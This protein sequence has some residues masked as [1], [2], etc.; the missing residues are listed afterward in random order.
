MT[1]PMAA[2][3]AFHLLEAIPASRTNA[4]SYIQPSNY[5]PFSLDRSLFTSELSKVPLEFTPEAEAAATVFAIPNP[6]GMLQRFEI[7][8]TQVMHPD[9]AKKF[10]EIKT[11][12]GQGLDD[13]SASVR[14]DITPAGFH[15]QVLSP[16]G[17]YYIDPYYHL[18]DSVY[19]SY[20]RSDL[21]LDPETE[22]LRSELS[23]TLETDFA[24]DESG[25]GAAGN[26]LERTGPTLRTYRLA[27]AATGEYTA[28]HG[29]TVAAGQAAIVTAINRVTG[30]WEVEM[31]IRLQLVPN[32]DLL[33]YT[34]AA[35]DPYTNNN[36]VTMLSENQTNV[37]NVIGSANYDIGHVF[38]TGGGGVASLGVVG[39]NSSK[40]RGVTGLP[41]PIGDPFY[42]DYVIHE[43]GHQFG[44]NHT[45][46]G[47]S[48]S[49]AGNRAASAAYEPGS[50]STIMAYAGICG[51][52]NL[53]NNSDPYFHSKSF[54]EI[55]NYVD[56]I[57]PSVGTRTSTGN[58]APVADAGPNFVIPAN[59]PFKLNGSGSDPNGDAITYQWEQR[60]L[61]PQQDVLA[62]DNG[63]SPLF[64]SWTPTSTP[65]RYFPRLSN[66]VNNSTVKGEK[67]ALTNRNLNFRLVVRDNRSG[68]GGVNT[69]D[70]LINVVNTGAA[71]QVTSPNS[72][73][74]WPVGSTQTV[75]WNVSGTDSGTI[76]TPGVN[77]LLSIDGGLTYP[78]VIATNVPNDGSQDIVVPNLPGSTAR[79]MVEGAGNI[80]FDISNTNFAI[81]PDTVAP[82]ASGSAPDIT[83][84][85]GT[86]QT[87]TVVYT[88]NVAIRA[89]D[90]G[91]GDI[92]VIAPNSAILSATLLSSTSGTDATPITATYQVLAP[93]GTWDSSDHGSYTIEMLAGE[94]G[95]VGGQFV[96][97]GLLGS[98]FVLLN[99]NLPG[100]FDGNGSL[101]CVDVDA[102]TQAIAAGSTDLTFDVTGDLVV[103]HQDLDEWVLNLKG[104]LFGDANLDFVVDGL[105]FTVW[106][107]NKFSTGTAWCSGD[108]TADGTT[109]GLDFTVWNM[110]KFQSAS[111][112]SN[113]VPKTT[114][115]AQGPTLLT[116]ETIRNV[117]LRPTSGSFKVAAGNQLC[118]GADD[119]R[120]VFT[121]RAWRQRTT[122][123]YALRNQAV[124]TRIHSASDIA[125]A[126]L[127]AGNGRHEIYGL[128]PHTVGTAAAGQT[129][130]RME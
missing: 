21:R 77:I 61:G 93:G 32:N 109:D 12:R 120:S 38:S 52:D 91:D 83:T 17:S 42:V 129:A 30:V 60:D 119:P 97:A 75:M 45:F 106:N 72:S 115:A 20:F 86:S 35:T 64:R 98:F 114:V 85:G 7:V 81:T 33:V 112:G 47:D 19:V 49:C 87:I 123:E 108:F 113:P 84:P 59:T 22:R 96:P 82:M 29:G 23:E 63:S 117:N 126:E 111:R 74:S 27:N 92:Q 39:V 16:A 73:V 55:V 31:T 25:G 40:A 118:S 9:L 15:A 51:N 46:N 56:V 10:P 57:R 62:P 48:G 128:L 95:D 3:E 67:Y 65:T 104:T 2:A 6:E 37:T 94:V 34:N 78:T 14:L 53:Q 41:S 70:M 50:G 54:D 4:V 105:D 36:G 11:F 80:F 76:N 102:L 71:F 44:A 28:F 99:P 101:D 58:L 18:D 43:M 122:N 89:S 125:L 110:F 5:Q 116:H 26:V 121:P 100:D 90:I 88:D 66:L 69:D 127:F 68:A 124:V 24:E 79:I 13:P 130:H 107:A 103:D 1:P 8:E